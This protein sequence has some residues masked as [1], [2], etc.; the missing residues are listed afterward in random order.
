MKLGAKLPFHKVS[1]SLVLR[2]AFVL[3]LQK[4]G[5][6]LQKIQRLHKKISVCMCVC[7]G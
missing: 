5:L 2:Q 7:G 6:I 4:F 3:E 1:G